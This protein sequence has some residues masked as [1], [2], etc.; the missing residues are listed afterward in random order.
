MPKRVRFRRK[1]T[2]DC[3]NGGMHDLNL[4]VPLRKLRA[5][6]PFDINCRLC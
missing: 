3:K 6:I 5:A 4:P 1:P 2:P